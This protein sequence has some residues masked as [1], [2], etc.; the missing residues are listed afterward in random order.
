MHAPR[1]D[2]VPTL[3]TWPVRANADASRLELEAS[4]VDAVD[5][6]SALLWIRERSWSDGCL[7]AME[8][9]YRCDGDEL[10]EI[11]SVCGADPASYADK[12]PEFNQARAREVETSY[13]AGFVG[14]EHPRPFRVRSRYRGG[15]LEFSYVRAMASV[16]DTTPSGG[17]RMR[18]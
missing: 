11:L 13:E 4:F 8:Y 12:G 1:A 16:L 7:C 10:V 18:S 9:G 2:G 6:R 15:H 3:V 17:L 14:N 5:A